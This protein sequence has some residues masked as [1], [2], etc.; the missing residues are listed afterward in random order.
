MSSLFRTLLI[1]ALGVVVV[2]GAVF[3][4]PGANAVVSPI[5]IAGGELGTGEYGVKAKGGTPGPGA[6]MALGA[7]ANAVLSLDLI[8]DGG[9]GNQRDDGVTTGAVSGRGTKI[10]VEVFATGVRTSLAG[11]VIK[12]DFDPSLLALVRAENSAFP[13][14]VPDGSIGTNFAA[15]SPVTLASSGFLARAEFETVA[16]VAG[17][18][19]SIGIASVTLAE[20]STSRDEVTTASEI[21]F[22]A[23]RSPD[24]DGDGTVGFPDFLALAAVFGTQRGHAAY[25]ARYDLDGDGTIGFGDFLTFAGAFGS[26]VP[27]S[28]GGGGGG[29]PDGFAP[30]DQQAFNSLAVGKRIRAETFFVDVTSAGRFAEGFRREKGRYTF[31]N[32][33]PNT[34]N[35]TQMYDDS[36]FLGGRCTLEMTFTTSATGTM[37]FTC[38]DGS[39]GDA[40]AWRTTDLSAPVF[41][42]ATPDTLYFRFLDTWRAGE[43]RAYDFE[44]RTK[45]P[46]GEWDEF[47]TPFSNPGDTPYTGYAITWFF[48]SELESGTTYEMRYRYRNSS[49]CDTGSPDPWSPIA[50]GTT[51]G[52]DSGGGG[53]GGSP[54]L[55]VNSPSVSDA[56]LTPG[57][58][59]TLRATVR[60]AGGAASASTTLR[61]YRSSDAAIST[62]DTE[63]GT[64]GVSSLSAGDT[65]AESISLNAPSSA[66]TYYYGACVDA[67]SGESDTDN[68]CSS[69]AQVEVSSG[70]GGRDGECV[71]GAT[72]A[73]G[74][75]CDVYGTGSSSKLP[76]TVLSDGRGRFWFFTSGNRISNPG[77]TINGVK[78]HFVASHQG[79]GIWK[80][81]EYIP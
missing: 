50:E 4:V 32:T 25:D 22:N 12:F 1:A 43:T 71:L 52:G 75:S 38:A 35:L 5:L 81:D 30:A 57:E 58:S 15:T 60:N 77:G 80:I 46:P 2:S 18:Q 24:F 7:N 9:S 67:V 45:T 66:G 14:T 79:G 59:F 49:S 34:G 44:L 8:A 48:G 54:D 51:A 17:R 21:R 63:V 31:T 70:G 10:A 78:Y 47:C 16:D 13:L 19:F 37:R 23:G 55:V 20:S 29:K 76:F 26:Q 39:E 33:G 74:K 11:M 6:K 69:G 53:G 64:D 65:S 61:Y 36:E 56:S 42:R 28:G 72:Y 62:S 3:L 73:P 40:E 41:A 68:N 27:P